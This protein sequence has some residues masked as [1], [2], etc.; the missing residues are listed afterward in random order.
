VKRVLVQGGVDA[1]DV[2]VIP[3]G[4]DPDEVRANAEQAP[5]IR[6]RLSLPAGAPLAVNAAALV[7]HK[8][9]LTLIRAAAAARTTAPQLHWVIAGEGPLREVLQREI[10]N[11]GL[12]DIVHLVGY[13]EP[14]DALIREASVFVMSSKEEGMGSVVLQALALSK[15]VVATAAGGLPEI[16]PAEWLVPAGDAEGLATMTLKAL[17]HPTAIPLD[18]RFTAKSMAEATLAQYRLLA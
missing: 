15:P 16:V 6:K 5:D 3:D 18:P 2:V 13:V 1:R 14:V 11:R 9:H 12:R 4:I 17:A 7:D 8:D 10:A